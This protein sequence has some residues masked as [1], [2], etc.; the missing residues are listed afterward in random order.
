MIRWHPTV[1][2][3]QIITTAAKFLLTSEEYVR[4]LVKFALTTLK[5]LLQ[6]LLSLKQTVMI[7]W[8]PTVQQTQIITPAAMFLLTF[9]EYVRKLVK[10]VSLTATYRTDCNT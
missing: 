2:Q 3:T 8:P 7:R 4:K 1:Q 5:L 6:Q 10:S 9:E